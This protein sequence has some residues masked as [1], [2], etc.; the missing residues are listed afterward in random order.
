MASYRHALAAGRRRLKGLQGRPIP[1]MQEDRAAHFAALDGDGHARGGRR[2]EHDSHVA[3]ARER[4]DNPKVHG[5]RYGDEGK[6]PGKA[7]GKNP[8]GEAPQQTLYEPDEGLLAF[9]ESL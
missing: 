1:E 7:L 6:E 3:G 5:R 8:F 2:P 4:P 9:L